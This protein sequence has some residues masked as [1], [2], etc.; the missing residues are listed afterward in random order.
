VI[1]EAEVVYRG[2]C[3]ACSTTTTDSRKDSRV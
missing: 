3:P 2:L 1:D